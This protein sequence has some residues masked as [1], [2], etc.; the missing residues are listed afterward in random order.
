MKKMG[1][2]NSVIFTLDCVRLKLTSTFTWPPQISIIDL[3]FTSNKICLETLK[4]G[5][6]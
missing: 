1:K 4:H 6:K 3:I 5:K 2:K